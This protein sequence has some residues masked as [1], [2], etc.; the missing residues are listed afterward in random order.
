[1]KEGNT[2]AVEGFIAF[3][4]RASYKMKDF[5]VVQPLT[6]LV[7]WTGAG[8]SKSWDARAP[9]G[10]ELFT[11]P[12][13]LL[14]DSLGIGAVRAL[15]GKEDVFDIVSAQTLRS[16]V[17]ALDVQERFPDVRG[18]YLDGPAVARIRDLLRRVI[19]KRFDDIF[20]QPS[21]RD[22]KLGIDGPTQAQID[23]VMFFS[24]LREHSDGSSS[25]A[26]GLRAH[27]IS[28]NYD[29]VIETILDS[30]V[31]PDDSHFLYTYRGI[32]PTE[33]LGFPAGPQIYDHWLVQNLIKINGGFEL[34]LTPSGYAF[35]Y[36]DARQK[37]VPNIILPSREQVYADPYFREVFPKAV[38]LLRDANALAIVGYSL[39][40]DD[41]SLRFILR[42][43]AESA[44]DGVG[45]TMFY[46]DMADA[47]AMRA[48]LQSLFPFLA[49]TQ[50][51]KTH[52]YSG[53]FAAFAAACNAG[54]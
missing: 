46:I 27:F 41:S 43:F 14:L 42:Q 22:E 13:D 5:N 20:P 8:F 18:R 44:E 34:I 19:A 2:E 4:D 35:D 26:E 25:V 10:E 3:V 48:R 12:D 9:I 17:Y 40:E 31:G 29:F 28:T 36:T 1:M 24:K 37:R 21:L 23:L 52:F 53:S 45:K 16:I 6:D 39:P 11:L 30:S 33:I 47:S 7:F 54:I 49:S 15:L 50:T 32:T 38:R 51:F